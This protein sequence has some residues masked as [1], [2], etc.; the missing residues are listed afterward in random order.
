MSEISES[1]RLDHIPRWCAGACGGLATL[2]TKFLSE[3]AETVSHLVSDGNY[4]TAMNYGLGYAVYAPFLI[5][6]GALVA[7]FSDEPNRRKLFYLGMVAPALITIVLNGRTAQKALGE[8]GVAKA[9]AQTTSV[10]TIPD[11]LS[12]I[13]GLKLVLNFKDPE[14]KFRVV[15]GSYKSQT[16][17]ALKAETIKKE[18]PKLSL[19]VFVGDR[20][21]GNEYYPVV[22][23]GYLSLNEAISLQESVQKLKAVEGSYLSPVIK[24]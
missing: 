11:K 9:Y 4:V 5:G 13:E 8:I 1:V 20:A 14:P 22:V 12:V 24:R 10:Q 17:A 7:V 2:L 19:Q 21:P 6:L 18:N 3:H 23:G 16:E 15:V